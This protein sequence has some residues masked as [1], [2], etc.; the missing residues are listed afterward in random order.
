MVI[1]IF[2]AKG[3][4]SVLT[5][6]QEHS[7]DK[8]QNCFSVLPVNTVPSM[9]DTSLTQNFP[10]LKKTLVAVVEPSPMKPQ[11]QH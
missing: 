4:P 2:V 9:A 11:W 8:L 6:A 10:A 5:T 7:V 1:G 3:P